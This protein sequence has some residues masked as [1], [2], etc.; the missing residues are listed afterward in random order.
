MMRWVWACLLLLGLVLVMHPPAVAGED[1]GYGGEGSA[2][3][4]GKAKRVLVMGFDGL[5]PL[6]MD[7]LMAAGDLPNFKALAAA[8]DYDR[9]GTATPPQ[10]PVCWAVVITGMDP[11]G[12]GIFDFIHRDPK[13]MLPF[14][15]TSIVNAPKQ[16]VKLGKWIL[17]LEAGSVEQ[18]RDGAA[19]WQI[20]DRGGVF[21]TVL[22]MPSN[23]PPVETKARTLAGMGTP[24]VRG[25][26]GIFH[27][28]TDDPAILGDKVSGGEVHA[29][30]VSGGVAQARLPGPRNSLRE[31]RPVVE[32]PFLVY[33]DAE[34]DVVRVDI[35]GE[36]M[37]LARGEWSRW[38]RVKF[39]LVPLLKSVH[40][41][42]RFHLVEA[43]PHLK[44]YA[45]PINLD[46]YEPDLPLS[47][48]EDYAAELAD[49][50]GLY[51]TQGIPSDTKA[52]SHGL[53]GDDGFMEQARVIL[54][55]ENRMFFHE[56]ERFE[57]GVL[58]GYWSVT[59]QVP[60]MMWRAMDPKHPLWTPELGAAHGDAIFE[61]YRAA[62]ATLGR[63]M[64]HVDE[65]T[66][67]LVI[68]DHGF[69]PWYREV[70][71]NTW[72]KDEGYLVLM[73]GARESD[74]ELF[75]NVDWTRTRAYGMGINGIYL[76][77][78]GREK[79]GIV[80]PDEAEALIDEISA[81][82]LALQDPANGQTAV[83]RVY[84]TSEIYHGRNRDQGPDMQVG[85]RRTYRCSDESAL[86]GLPRP[87][88]RD[89]MGAWSGCHLMETASVPGVI[90][91]NRKL[92]PG[93]KS[94]A[95]VAPTILS[96]FGIPTPADMV[97]RP[98]L[99]APAPEERN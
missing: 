62:D 96:E 98:I 66:T 29:V 88:I 40:G 9:L 69:A 54:E 45:S 4:E 65:A 78:A 18:L 43:H 16:T 97:G 19:F 17:P 1:P 2:V 36:K 67:L 41:I 72:L 59:D 75:S 21:S 83:S 42:V 25:T 79:W 12:T 55:E 53:I 94:L 82:L 22:K 33:V 23:F 74:T 32:V 57:E 39:P 24:D 35:A 61:I 63:T 68:S 15:S 38:V 48:P 47:T 11:G 89:R 95:D 93:D 49:A 3:P 20:L 86:G 90:F 56:L 13:T 6:L 5:D 27:F 77:R 34:R 58:F 30:E 37:L 81:K 14:L 51:Y 84:R 8:G 92:V 71:L 46:P 31:D 76:N 28:F 70:H 91:T 99:A 7:A 85:Y 26:Y 60:H 10:S 44:L 73:P 64:P 87:V 52:L 50:I 80:Q